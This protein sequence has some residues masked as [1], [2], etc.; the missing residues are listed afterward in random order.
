MAVVYEEERVVT[1]GTGECVDAELRS[2]AVFKKNPVTKHLRTRAVSLPHDCTG[3]S[4][5]TALPGDEKL[6]ESLRHPRLLPREC[7]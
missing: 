4:L 7:Q 5:T 2:V 3:H 6:L 1:T